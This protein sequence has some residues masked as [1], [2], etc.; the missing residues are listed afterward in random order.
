MIPDVCFHHFIQVPD[1]ER[2]YGPFD[3]AG[4]A[5]E[6]RMQMAREIG[7][8]VLPAKITTPYHDGVHSRNQTSAGQHSS[9]WTR[10]EIRFIEPGTAYKNLSNQPRRHGEDDRTSHSI[11]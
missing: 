9:D 8:N 2:L 4:T 6:A 5:Q 7:T 3:S 1:T 10:A 11:K